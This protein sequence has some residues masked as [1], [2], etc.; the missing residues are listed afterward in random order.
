[1][2]SHTHA[3]RQYLCRWFVWEANRTFVRGGVANKPSKRSQLVKDVISRH[4]PLGFVLP[5]KKCFNMAQSTNH[6]FDKPQ[7]QNVLLTCAMSDWNSEILRSSTGDMET[8][9]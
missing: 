2:F 6:K 9:I 8:N 4:F 1:M 3:F 7:L 5:N